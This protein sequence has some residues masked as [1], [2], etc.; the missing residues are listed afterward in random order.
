MARSSL[1]RAYI[2]TT[3]SSLEVG[4]AC[5]TIIIIIIMT[6]WRGN[7][8]IFLPSCRHAGLTRPQL[9]RLATA[10]EEEEGEGERCVKVSRRDLPFVLSQVRIM[11]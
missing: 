8:V 5:E 2:E 11:C 4:V 3:P 9:E 7:R 10:V 6:A 1:V